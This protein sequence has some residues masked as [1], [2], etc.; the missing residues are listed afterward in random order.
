MPSGG[1]ILRAARSIRAAIRA[2]IGGSHNTRPAA[3]VSRP[4]IAMS[5]PAG[6]M[7]NVCAG[8]A[9]DSRGGPSMAM[10]SV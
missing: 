9:F 1:L 2:R 6:T 4:G 7:S 5:I 10:T 3:V 8:G